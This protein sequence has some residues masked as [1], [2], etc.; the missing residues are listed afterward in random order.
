MRSSPTLER[1]PPATGWTGF[2]RAVNGPVGPLERDFGA[3]EDALDD[4]CGDADRRRTWNSPR[5]L[6]YRR[7]RPILFLKPYR[8]LLLCRARPRRQSVTSEGAADGPGWRCG[9]FRL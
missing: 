5:P 4:G 1:S 3:G 7:R 2:N 6:G 8:H 9:G